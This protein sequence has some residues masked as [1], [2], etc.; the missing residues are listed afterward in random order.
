MPLPVYDGNQTASSI[1]IG[2]HRYLRDEVANLTNDEI[3]ELIQKLQS[4]VDNADGPK[5]HEDIDGFIEICRD[6]LDDRHLVCALVREGL[7]DGGDTNE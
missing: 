5:R 4:C 7:I 6:E 2:Y 1:L 3:K